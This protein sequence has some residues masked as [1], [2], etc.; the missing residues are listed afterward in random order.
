MVPR[1]VARDYFLPDSS[2]PGGA[3]AEGRH[4]AL[5]GSLQRNT[6]WKGFVSPKADLAD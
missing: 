4:A 3:G 5:L 6:R 2:R 1:R